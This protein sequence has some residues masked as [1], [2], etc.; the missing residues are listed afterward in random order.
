MYEIWII[1]LK[2]RITLFFR[3]YFV[4]HYI[5]SYYFAF[6]LN[7][8]WVQPLLEL[9]FAHLICHWGPG[10]LH[11][12][13][14]KWQSAMRKISWQLSPA[15]VDVKVCADAQWCPQD[16]RLSFLVLFMFT[17]ILPCDQVM[18]LAGVNILF[19][20][21]KSF[22][23]EAHRSKRLSN[24]ALANREEMIC[25][26][27]LWKSEMGRNEDFSGTLLEG[28]N[29]FQGHRGRFPFVNF[30][31]HGWALHQG[32]GVKELPKVPKPIRAHPLSLDTWLPRYHQDT[33]KKIH[34]VWEK[35]KSHQQIS[36]NLG[37]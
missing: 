34:W 17:M 21:N 18:I 19:S 25:T 13:A 28:K 36:T 30:F 10:Q 22:R 24:L 11:L 23:T 9:G 35:E 15:V 37:T 8:R 31:S 14:F 4:I 6:H 1:T 33:R 20:S 12:P 27:V 32:Q 5:H 2:Q 16:P 29:V 3:R 7:Q 26:H